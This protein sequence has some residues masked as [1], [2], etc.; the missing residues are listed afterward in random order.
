MRGFKTLAVC[1]LVLSACANLSLSALSTTSIVYKVTKTS[2]DALAPLLNALKEQI[3]ITVTGAGA[4][5]KSPCN[6]CF[7]N[8]QVK[9]T[10]NACTNRIGSDHYKELCTLVKTTME[11]MK[12]A[13]GLLSNRNS[14]YKLESQIEGEW[15]ELTKL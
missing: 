4:T 12:S 6:L 8:F 5:M 3:E 11:K 7:Y 9:T 10:T 2:K 1:L 14:P 15:I 13:N